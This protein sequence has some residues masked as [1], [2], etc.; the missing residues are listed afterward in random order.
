MMRLM[1][2]GEKGSAALKKTRGP[3]LKSRMPLTIRKMRMLRGKKGK[4]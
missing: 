2:T 3:H 1:F 4:S